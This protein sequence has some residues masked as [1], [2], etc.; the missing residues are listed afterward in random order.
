MQVLNLR[1]DEKIITSGAE[2]MQ[3]VFNSERVCLTAEN[4]KRAFCKRIALII[5]QRIPPGEM[6]I[7]SILK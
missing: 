1:N 5:I 4:N 7:Q 3:I 2:H 6:K